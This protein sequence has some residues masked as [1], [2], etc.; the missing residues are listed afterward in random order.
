MRTALVLGSAACVWDDVERALDLGELQ[1]VVGCN[2]AGLHWPGVMDGW[3]SLHR[4][5]LTR[6]WVARR[7]LMGLPDHKALFSIGS[8]E[9]RFPGQTKPGSS[10][11]FALKVALSDLGFDRA[12]LCGMPLDVD[13]AHFDTPGPWKPASQYRIGW[14]QALP[15]IRD[16]ARSMGGWT[17]QLLGQATSEWI[18]GD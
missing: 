4:D 8:T 1:G 17:A 14:E 11:L 18:K 10:G 3:C 5:K 13:E 2:H 12:V 7:R 6:P 16:R 15:H 9:H